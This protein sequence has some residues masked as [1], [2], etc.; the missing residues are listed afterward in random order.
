MVKLVNVAQ[1]NKNHNALF[2]YPIK[3]I[4]LIAQFNQLH[5]IHVNFKWIN[6]KIKVVQFA[7]NKEEVYCFDVI[8]SGVIKNKTS[9]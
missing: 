5:S 9:I 7:L 3:I 6:I 1:L 2:L 8:H 4:Q